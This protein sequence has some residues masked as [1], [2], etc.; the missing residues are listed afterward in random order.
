MIFHNVEQ[1]VE[2][3]LRRL[4]FSEKDTMINYLGRESDETLFQPISLTKNRTILNIG[5]GD[6]NFE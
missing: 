6:E 4:A 2:V 1:E 3:L 5:K